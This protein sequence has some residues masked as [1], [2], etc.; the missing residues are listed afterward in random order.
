M[1]ATSITANGGRARLIVAPLA[2][3][4]RHLAALGL[5]AVLIAF[6][7][8][9]FWVFGHSFEPLS[10]WERGGVTLWP[11]HVTLHNYSQ[12]IKL[13]FLRNVLASVVVASITTVITLVISSLAGY[14]I[15]RL[16]IR[17]RGW[18][19]AFVILAGFFPVLAMIGPLYLMFRNLGLLNTWTG[20]ALADL[21]YTLPLCTWLL[22][23]LFSQLPVEIEE[24]AMVDG[25]SRLVAMWRVVIPLAAPAMVTAAIISFILAWSDFAFSVSF[26]FGPTQ[27]TAPR[28]ILYLGSAKFFTDYNLIDAT[29]MI[30]ALPILLLVLVAQRRIV[31]GLTAGAVK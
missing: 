24:A 28:A 2:W 25:C 21:I 5:I 7:F 19:L 9:L 12:A 23:S 17:G 3:V 10:E 14:A 29:V 22:A 11:S 30:T 18:V 27:Y 8:P 20:V 4:R 15:A 26:L 31:T 1:S 13:G 16:P 6:M